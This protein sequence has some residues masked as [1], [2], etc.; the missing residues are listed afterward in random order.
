VLFRSPI[1]AGM[2]GGSA[3]AA[4]ALRLAMAIAPGRAEELDAVAA[5]LGADVPSQLTPGLTLGTGAGDLVEHYDPLGPH[6]YV[7]LPSW[8]RLSTAEVYRE[9]DR[10][11]LARPAAEL[12]ERYE[13]LVTSLIAGGRLAGEMIVNDLQPA[14]LSLCPSIADAL[15]AVRATGAEHVIVSGS[16]P[17][18]IGLFWGQDAPARASTAARALAGA[19]PGATAATPVAPPYGAPEPVER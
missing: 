12:R 16:G 6:A 13:Q 2:G 10:L 11:A 17:T 18:V 7:I 19:H 1:A 8:E 15:A 9:A 4:A 14:A 5:A 3:D